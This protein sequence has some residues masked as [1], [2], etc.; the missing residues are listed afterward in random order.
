MKR[1][2]E[3][4]AHACV[5]LR[6]RLGRYV[7]MRV[8]APMQVDGSSLQPSSSF[9]GLTDSRCAAM[10][11]CRY[12]PYFNDFG[13]GVWLVLVVSLPWFTFYLPMYRCTYSIHTAIPR[14]TTYLLMQAAAHLCFPA[15]VLFTYAFDSF[16][17][18]CYLDGVGRQVAGSRPG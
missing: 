3:G 14:K 9:P 18:A 7:C 1:L 11:L 8:C 15:D 16:S 2:N 12:L 13:G 10:P 4:F 5:Y 6:T 17:V